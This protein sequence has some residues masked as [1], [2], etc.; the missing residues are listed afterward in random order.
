MLIEQPLLTI[1]LPLCRS[2]FGA[3][4]AFLSAYLAASAKAS[5]EVV[6]CDNNPSPERSHIQALSCPQERYI[7]NSSNLGAAAKFYRVYLA[8]RGR[9]ILFAGEDN[10]L[11][12]HF[13]K[14]IADLTESGVGKA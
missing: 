13:G 11:S 14:V 5:I 4:R 1:G 2:G 6:V 8:A 7:V 3:K 10:C 12:P 9:D